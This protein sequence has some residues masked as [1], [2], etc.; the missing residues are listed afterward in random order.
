VGSTE[1]AI[2]EA[3]PLVPFSGR[4]PAGGMYA[5]FARS[6]ARHAEA[7]R[8][9]GKQPFHRS[10]PIYLLMARLL[11]FV[12]EMPLPSVLDDTDTDRLLVMLRLVHGEPRFDI[13]PELIAER[14]RARLKL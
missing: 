1:R 4:R 2:V 12:W 8:Q 9:K 14:R 7:L 5:R 13:A 6:S 11:D 3:M 10:L